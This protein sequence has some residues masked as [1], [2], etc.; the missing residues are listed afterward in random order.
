MGNP[1]W[2]STTWW[3]W[4]SIWFYLYIVAGSLVG[5]SFTLAQH[6][7]THVP[8]R[9]SQ[10]LP[11]V[12]QD[13]SLANSLDALFEKSWTPEHDQQW[14]GPQH[15]AAP[16]KNGCHDGLTMFDMFRRLKRWKPGKIQEWSEWSMDRYGQGPTLP[17]RHS[18]ANRIRTAIFDDPGSFFM[19]RDQKPKSSL[20]CFAPKKTGTWWLIP[21]IV[22]GLVHLSY[23]WDFCRVNPLKKLGWTNPL[24]KWDEPPS[25]WFS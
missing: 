22:S 18:E 14:L 16:P 5:K 19:V 23:T 13:L 24:T 21:R 1:S 7:V 3:I 9:D 2:K 20:P 4:E 12:L 6:L 15:A 17:L 11:M 10:W 25:S 8:S